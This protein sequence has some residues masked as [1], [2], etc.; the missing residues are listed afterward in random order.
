MAT[1]NFI[2]F[3][4]TGSPSSSR[5]SANTPTAEKTASPNI[6]AAWYTSGRCHWR[7]VRPNTLIEAPD[8]YGRAVFPPAATMTID[9][10]KPGEN[11]HRQPSDRPPE[12]IGGYPPDAGSTA[13]LR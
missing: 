2:G 3:A 5:W 9:V 12:T 11:A 8:R 6:N 13:A 10:P 1:P 4:H 7:T